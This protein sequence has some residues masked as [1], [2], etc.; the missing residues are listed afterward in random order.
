[1]KYLYKYAQAAYPYDDL[2]QT[3]AK[4]NQDD[5]E[6]ELLDTGIF[7]ENR[8]FD[9]FVEYAKEAPDDLLIR[10]SVFNRGPDTATLHLLPTLWFR[11]DWSDNGDAVKPALRALEAAKSAHVV[12]ADHPQLGTRYLYAEGDGRLLFT[13]NETNK[14]RLW[15]QQNI[16]PYV[17]DGIDDYVVQGNHAA[18]NPA[19]KGT[20][21]AVQHVLNVPP[22]GR[23]VVQLRLTDA[24]P[25]QLAKRYPNGDPFGDHFTAVC[26]TRQAEADAF[27]GD[28]LPAKLPADVALVMRQALAGMLWSKQY[29]EYDVTRWL[30]Q[31][32]FTDR[33]AAEAHAT[34]NGQWYHMASHD[35]ISMPDK[36]EY[37]WFAAWDLAFHTVAL[38]VVDLDFAKDQVML[39][40]NERYLHPNGQ[41][42][43]YE[44]NFS[45]VNPP[46]HAW[47][48]LR[49][50]AI[51]KEQRGAGDLALLKDGFHKL[52]LYYTW[53]VNRKDPDNQ[54][55]FGGG[56]LGLDNISVFNR[57]AP[58]PTGGHLAQS[59]GSAWMV[60]F[61]LSMLQIALELSL[62]DPAYQSMANKF[63][64]QFLWIQSAM[65]P[66]NAS[67][68]GLWDEDD[69][70][71][72]DV[73]RLPD[74]RSTP[75]KVR[76]LVGLLPLAACSMMMPEQVKQLP[77]FV[78]WV[79]ELN[80]QRPQLV[81]G[82][83]TM[84]RPG[85]GNRRLLAAVDE[86]KLRRV[87]ARM[88][89]ENEFL[90]PYG[91]RSLSRFH[92]AHPYVVDVGGT[93]YRVDYLP[94]ESNSRM[95]GGNSNWRGPIWFPMNFMLIQGLL[96]L[97]TYYGDDFTVECPTGSGKQMTLWQVS[98][99]IALRLARIFLRDQ[100][101]RRPL[102]GGI[103]QFQEDPD[104]RDHIQF[105]EYFHGD[106]G[107]GLGASHQTG[108]T[109]L[110]AR[111]VQVFASVSDFESAF[112][113]AV[114]RWNEP[115]MEAK[116]VTAPDQAAD[117]KAK[118]GAVQ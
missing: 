50:Y 92:Q 11:N 41:I 24:P 15:S 2:V 118:G 75:L 26:Q 18:V 17:K 109:G 21:V 22:G 46:V 53:W 20:K 69:G 99:E 32:G 65:N 13:E 117:L 74:G 115:A 4:R 56:F 19:Q 36:W 73:L 44:W 60:F 111:I 94:A 58:L 105:H 30:R 80:E 3:N 40:L 48:L 37:P 7:N 43:A 86:V 104:W 68:T 28:I 112:M 96:D 61:S 25:D 101:G 97:Y 6:Y 64:E 27:Y 85:V 14:Q 54:D 113:A 10:I 38:A 90:S 88:L 23:A 55:V 79:K 108:W 31:H 67:S 114:A 62:H 35:I 39:L 45:D 34:R 100:D 66:S 110:I 95:F 5:F 16:A 83:P 1:M 52:M 77:E 102:Y 59:D 82:I 47:A 98:Q 12:Q 8:Y 76:S 63:Y 89:D 72:Y 9:V 87:L 78:A 84:A 33:T 93:E 29:Y 81:A 51:E 107:A 106:N 116:A 91:I 42:P 103:S 70:F 49:L 57:S 71:F